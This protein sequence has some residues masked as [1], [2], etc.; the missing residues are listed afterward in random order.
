MRSSS[1]MVGLL[2][3]ACG[4]SSAVTTLGGSLGF[5]V[6]S[7]GEDFGGGECST[8]SGQGADLGENCGAGG[9]IATVR[10]ET[11]DGGL[12]PGTYNVVDP[13][14]SS[15]DQGYLATAEYRTPLADGGG[16]TDWASTGQIVI[17]A[18]GTSGNGV[19]GS[20]NVTIGFN[21]G[22]TGTL[23]GSFDTTQ[24]AFCQE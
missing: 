1:L 9:R 17:D 14:A 18:V 2:L 6:K 15:C 13:S 7:V 12:Q 21:D 3:V 20:F 11:P 8:W 16:Y 19:R 22:G 23:S 5:P 4:G 24:L 10:I